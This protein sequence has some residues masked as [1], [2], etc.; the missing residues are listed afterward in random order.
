MG[1]I[2][3]N[4]WSLKFLWSV[5]AS[6]L[7]NYYS[8]HLLLLLLLGTITNTITILYHYYVLLL[9][10]PFALSFSSLDIAATDGLFQHEAEVGVDD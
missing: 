2:K 1:K 6:F 9:F 8:S 4:H 5:N 3:Q 7:L 10:Q